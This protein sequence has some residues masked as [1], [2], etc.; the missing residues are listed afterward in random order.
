MVAGRGMWDVVNASA[1]SRVPD[2]LTMPAT[3]TM[4][5]D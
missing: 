4:M 5:P 1:A 3:M 2:P